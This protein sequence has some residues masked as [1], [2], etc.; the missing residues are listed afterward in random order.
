[1]SIEK[2]SDLRALEAQLE[3]R[4]SHCVIAQFAGGVYGRGKVRGSAK[5]R[6]HM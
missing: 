6:S 2:L 5:E 1:V 4:M 3:E